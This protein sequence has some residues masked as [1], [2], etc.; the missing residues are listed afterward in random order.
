MK[1]HIPTPRRTGEYVNIYRPSA[2][3]YRGIKT[4]GFVPN[5]KYENWI[6][7]DF[8]VLYDNGEWHIVGITHPKPSGFTNAF[9]YD[10]KNIHEAEYQLFH[11][12][13]SAERFSELMYPESFTD[14]E[15][16]LYPA[17]RPGERPEIWAPHLMKRD[18]RFEVIYS[19]G[20]MRSASTEDFVNFSRRVLFECDFAFA[21]DPYI[22][23]EDGSYYF[24]YCDRK[25]LSMRVSRDME[26]W[27]EPEPLMRELFPNA[28]TE[29]PF[30]M[31][32][33]EY[34]YLLWCIYDGRNGSYD[35]RTFVYAAK[36]IRELGKYAPIAM[37]DAHAPE[38][39]FDGEDYYLLSVFYP[40][41]GVSAAKLEFI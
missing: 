8:S 7:N 1:E 34:Y 24:I 40:E 39:V 16:L 37:L 41:N 30:L 9:D 4:D 14:C 17:D 11:C 22:F 5:E 33:G 18:G 15:K 32:R 25:G 6:C 26:N 21:R 12:R 23:G 2:D 29:S 31:K 10:S 19:P 13:A 20:S 28:S 3:I 27:S 36:S 38:I 35:N